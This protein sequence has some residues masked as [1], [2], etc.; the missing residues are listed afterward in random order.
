M[1]DLRFFEWDYDNDLV[2][3]F[4]RS[5]DCNGCGACC[6][7]LIRFMVAGGDTLKANHNPRNGGPTTDGAG[8]WLSVAVGGKARY[9][10]MVSIEKTDHRCS[11]L[12]TDN[13][14]RIHLGKSLFSRAWPMNPS[15]IEP[16]D[17]CSYAFREV[18]RW[19]I[20]EPEADRA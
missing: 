16:F 14:C 7:G 12:T 6:M 19:K 20:S 1:P 3:E 17:R 2:T 13:K 18:G 11:M 4:E 10:K 8:V 5:G 9:F 15:Q